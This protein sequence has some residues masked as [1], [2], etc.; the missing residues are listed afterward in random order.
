[1]SA[2]RTGNGSGLTGYD[3]LVDQAQQTVDAEAVP[4]W[5]TARC[6]FWFHYLLTS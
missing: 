4:V 5:L 1:M 2:K 6:K 3:A